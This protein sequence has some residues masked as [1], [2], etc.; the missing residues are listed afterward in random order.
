MSTAFLE[1]LRPGHL[2]IMIWPLSMPLR[3]SHLAIFPLIQGVDYKIHMF[4]YPLTYARP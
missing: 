4:A 1:V 2:A 3:S